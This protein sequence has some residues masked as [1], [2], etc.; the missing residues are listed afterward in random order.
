MFPQ[1]NPSLADVGSPK[2]CLGLLTL[3]A[4]LCSGNS[5]DQGKPTSVSLIFSCWYFLVQENP[6]GRQIASNDNDILLKYE[7]KFVSKAKVF[8]GFDIF[9]TALCQLSVGFLNRLANP[10]SM[11]CN[12]GLRLKNE[13][14]KT[15]RVF[16]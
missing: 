5:S 16:R 6:R 11:N 1:N 8:D 14:E 4:L 7:A 10:V 3:L 9:L 12:F 15:S 2:Q 13:H